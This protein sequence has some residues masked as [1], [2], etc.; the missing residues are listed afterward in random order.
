[1][2]TTYSFNETVPVGFRPSD[3]TVEVSG[4]VTV[5]PKYDGRRSLIVSVRVT[6]EVLRLRAHL[7][8][9]RC[10]AAKT[11]Q[12]GADVT[13]IEEIHADKILYYR[14]YLAERGTSWTR[15][16]PRMYFTALTGE[17]A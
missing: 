3:G 12:C 2:T 6:A 5:Q 4:R 9:K 7:A 1:M 15:L 10:A 13:F 14:V 8:A 16:L 11:R 17:P